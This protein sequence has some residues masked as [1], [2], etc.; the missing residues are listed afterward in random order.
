MEVAKETVRETLNEAKAYLAKPDSP[1]LS[2][3]DT[4]IHFVEPIIAALDW[5]GF[6]VVTREYFVKSSHEYID[7]IMSSGG[8]HVLAIEAKPLQSPLVEKNAAQLVQYCAVEGI[9]WAALTNGC[10]LQLFNTFLKPDLQAKRVLNL[11]LLA[12]GNNEEFESLFQQLNLLSRE[13]ITSN[14][15]I[16]WLRERRMDTI[17]RAALLDPHTAT[18]KALRKALTDAD[19]KATAPEIVTWART[20]L[21]PKSAAEEKAMAQPLPVTL[22][23]PGH[24]HTVHDTFDPSA[25]YIFSGH[26]A[27]LLPTMQTLQDKLGAALPNVQWRTMKHYIA[28]A[29]NETTFLAIKRRGS[30]LVIGVSFP[31]NSDFPLHEEDHRIFKWS[32]LTKAFAVA[33][34]DDIN[35]DVLNVL[36][37]SAESAKM[38]S[39][40]HKSYYG[41]TVKQLIDAGLAYPGE[42]LVLLKG[43]TEIAQATLDASGRIQWN[44]A[45]YQSP[46]DQAFTKAMGR[47]SMNGWTHWFVERNGSLV[48]FAALRQKLNEGT[49]PSDTKPPLFDG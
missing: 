15:A 47:K 35:A 30:S 2:E 9:E 13:S 33:K 41:V 24:K 37:K 39:G 20:Q 6:G 25:S 16:I 44:G 12:Y 7:Y 28:A 36:N 34:P 21:M 8:Q 42:K 48:D 17:L 38:D 3:A 5:K 14:A 19:I 10:E 45:L 18:V 49:H 1:K 23:D 32:R 43:T 29:S 22:P 4:K 26:H 46:S 31:E 40:S 11:E 27:A